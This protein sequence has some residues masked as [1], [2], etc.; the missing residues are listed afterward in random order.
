MIRNSVLLFKIIILYICFMARFLKSRKLAKGKAP[1]SFVFIGKQKMEKSRI[2][3]IQYNENEILETEEEHIEQALQS[4][5][6]NKVTWINI[7]GIHDAAVIEKVGHRLNISALLLDNIPNTDQR[8]KFLEDSENII[9]I[10][11]AFFFNTDNSSIDTEQISFILGKEYLVTFQEKI[12]DHFE[13]VR[14]RL[15]EKIGVIRTKGPDYLLHALTDALVDNYF[16]GI[17]NLGHQVEKL[18]S[19]LS[20]NDKD[21]ASL[22]Y[23]YKTEFTYLRKHIRPLKE[24][25]T[26][27]LK[28][29]S[30][31]IHKKSMIYFQELEDLV[32]QSLEAIEIYYTMV[33][34]QLNIYHTNVSN[35]VN[36]VMKVLTIFASIFIPLTFI[37][38][39]YGT[40]FD[41][42]P[43]LHYR[44]SYYIMW[45]IMVLVAVVMLW[46]FRRKKWL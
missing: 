44:Y 11:K 3:V 4:I 29:E 46:F 16:I 23:F 25:M 42:L 45:G 38:G 7:D 21:I 22:I 36:D 17:E 19:R 27:L 34:D 41:Y 35:R 37:A 33:S 1:G 28:T 14:E 6:K 13:V 31:V 5:E 12:G 43:E 39:I 40:N 15:R 32:I 9:L 2:R 18:E 30:G 8:P 10:I 26:R 24:V 20:G